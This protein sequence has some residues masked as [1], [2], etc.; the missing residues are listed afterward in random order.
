MAPFILLTRAVG[1][2]IMT[3]VCLFLAFIM[4]FL[5]KA[6]QLDYSEPTRN[7]KPRTVV[8]SSNQYLGTQG[9]FK[10]SC[11]EKITLAVYIFYLNL[12]DIYGK[13]SSVQFSR[14]VMSDSL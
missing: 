8:S 9:C 10:G 13:F 11:L 7:H 2:E 6:E 12:T 4:K 3:F 14:S 1:N 5:K